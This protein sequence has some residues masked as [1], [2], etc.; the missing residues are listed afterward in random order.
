M[1]QCLL[2]VSAALV[3]AAGL[4]ASRPAKAD[5]SVGAI[6]AGAGAIVAL[7]VILNPNQPDADRE[8][9]F[10]GSGI[11]DVVDNDNRAV[12]Y[13]VE[14]WAPYTFF[15]FRPFGGVIGTSD[16]P[17]GGYIGI[18]HDLNI[19]RHI[20]LSADTAAVGMQRGGGGSEGK[21][22]G[23][24]PLL[25]SGVSAAYRFDDGIRITAAFHHMSH[26]KLFSD[27]NPGTET[28]TIGVAIP[29]DV[30]FGGQ[31]VKGKHFWPKPW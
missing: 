20:V 23:A 1:R 5:P 9:V 12:L 16:G 2:A 14:Y 30:L 31:L 13:N 8:F 27:L 25:R 19:G 6:A 3:L 17:V 22:L 24:V 10:G 4:T 18:R 15:R 11:F 7:G 21:D 29:T 26:G 28:L